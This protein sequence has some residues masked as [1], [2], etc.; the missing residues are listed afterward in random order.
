MK[1]K[2]MIGDIPCWWKEYGP[3]KCKSKFDTPKRFCP[4]C[5]LEV[6]WEEEGCILIINNQ[7]LFPNISIHTDCAPY[8]VDEDVIIS[9]WEHYKKSKG[10]LEKALTEGK[11]WFSYIKM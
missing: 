11:P 5:G 9:I 6:N 2:V 7:L 10:A 1:H 3:A 4:R 8:G